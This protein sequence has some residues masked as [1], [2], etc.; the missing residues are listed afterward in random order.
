MADDAAAPGAPAEAKAEAATTAP[1]FGSAGTF[2]AATGFAG[3]SAEGSI[4]KPA[5][6][7]G[8]EGGDGHQEE[9]CQATFKPVVELDEVETTTGEEL[10]NQLLEMKCK[11]YR[12]DS[13]ASEWK[14]RGVGYVRLL[15]NKENN[16]IRLLMRQEKTLKIRA[17]HIVMPGTKLEE[18]SGSD[19]TWV[20]TT[21][22]F[23]EEQLK[24]EMFA[25]RF[26]SVEKAQEF[27]AEFGK[28]M[29]TNE[30]LLS[31]DAAAAPKDESKEEAEKLA[32][33]VAAKATVEN[34][35]EEKKDD[36]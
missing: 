30:K 29:E 11:L 1:V 10:E 7:D 8:E 19:K 18:H 28:A 13:D 15:E 32:D 27:K 35:E 33:E 6:G 4:A 26:G 9:E 12:F 3:F 16:K 36:A 5:G 25:I 22:D 17:N 21:V 24:S 20:Y 2:G 31:A 34:T 23:A 14:E